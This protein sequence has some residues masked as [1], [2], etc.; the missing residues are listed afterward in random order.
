[1]RPTILDAAPILGCTDLSASIAFYARLGFEN[2]IQFTRYAILRRD[3][4]EIHLSL[5]D[6]P[7][8]YPKAHC[9][10]RVAST[11]AFY[12]DLKERGIRVEPPIE[13]ECY[14]KEVCV[15]DLDGNELKFAEAV[16]DR[17]LQFEARR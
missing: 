10:L 11:E 5:G 8:P 12:R 15:W 17:M 16:E 9:F 4:A 13:R 7:N 1:M 14:V 6:G 2:V 3:G